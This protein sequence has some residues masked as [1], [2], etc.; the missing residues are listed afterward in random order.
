MAVAGVVD[1]EDSIASLISE[2]QKSKRPR[3]G[4]LVRALDIPAKRALGMFDKA[5]PGFDADVF[6]KELAA[7]ASKFYG[8]AGL[9]FIRQLIERDVTSERVRKLVGE[10]VAVAL[11]DV[12]KNN[13]GQVARVAER[14]GLIAVAGKLYKRSCTP[15][16]SPGL[17][18]LT[19]A[20]SAA[21]S[22]ERASSSEV[23]GSTGS[24]TTR[25]LE[26]GAL[27]FIGAALRPAGSAGDVDL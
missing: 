25:A 20:M 5:H 21:K 7:A 17:S 2:D 18:A 3:A 16:M 9:A 24:T 22:F 6:T 4:Q 11:K 14:F 12:D 27:S 1:G 10:F 13:H 15:A 19:S 23:S 26:L 8:T